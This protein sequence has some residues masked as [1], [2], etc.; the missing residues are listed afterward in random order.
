MGDSTKLK[1]AQKKFNPTKLN[2][3]YKHAHATE[4]H[5]SIISETTWWFVNILGPAG[6]MTKSSNYQMS[7]HG[8]VWPQALIMQVILG[9]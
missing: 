8:K 1:C 5:D 7:L 4:S 2:Q 9:F 3:N 6:C